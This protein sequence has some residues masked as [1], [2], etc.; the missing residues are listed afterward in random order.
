M[1]RKPAKQA[2][3]SDSSDPKKS[4]LTRIRI[5]DATARVLSEK[6]YAGTRLTDV[7]KYAE[8]QAPAIYYYFSSREDLIEEVMFAGISDMRQHLRAELDRLPDGT[9]PMERIVFAVETH[10]RHELELSDYATASIRNSGQ[11]PEH[12]RSRQKKEAAAYDRIWRKLFS[13][14]R[15]D[16]QLRDDI[17]DKLAQAL[18][19]GALNWAAEWWD[20]RR[21]SLDTIVANA[22]TFVRH[23]LSPLPAPD[24]PTGRKSKRKTPA[25]N[26]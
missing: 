23:S 3:D 22:Q 5:L 21:A 12:L 14:A 20:P 19:V 13:D 4:E 7:A 10:L 9:P 6:G 8:L 15:A 18:V 17:D 2:V 16:G 24:E 1:A 25:A 26:S 11:I